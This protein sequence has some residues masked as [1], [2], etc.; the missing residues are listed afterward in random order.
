MTS[1]R[2][3]TDIPQSGRFEMPTASVTVIE[4]NA[5]LNGILVNAL[6][7]AGFSAT[8]YTSVEGY[9]AAKAP[10]PQIFLLDLNLPGEDGL[11][12]ARRI[13][14]TR[15]ETGIVMLTARDEMDQR[16]HGYDSGADI[17]LT[18]PSSVD[19]IL[20]AMTA[21]NRRLP[22]GTQAAPAAPQSL[23]LN[24]RKLEITGPAGPVSIGV[25]EAE[26][27]YHCA[28]G[29]EGRVS[30]D[31][32]RAYL[33]EGETSSKVALEL[34]VVRIRKRL[35]NAGIEGRSIASV[36]NFGYQLLVPIHLVG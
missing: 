15:P 3:T 21:L 33:R 29:P 19:E 11:S 6:K 24:R 2:P 25:D 17:Y 4:D 5:D 27:L 32:I 7:G 18:K 10:T 22:Q 30:L 1:L 16:R 35:A 26:F 12:F 31:Q 13:R 23:T 36:R 8:G 28:T 14:A 9:E 34:K 20:G